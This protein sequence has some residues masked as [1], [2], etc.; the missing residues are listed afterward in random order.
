MEKYP[1]KNIIVNTYEIKRI[2]E[3]TNTAL[4]TKILEKAFEQ[5]SKKHYSKL[6]KKFNISY[7]SLC[8]EN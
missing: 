2:K 6:I 1:P 8:E 4:A 3:S 7:R 5:F